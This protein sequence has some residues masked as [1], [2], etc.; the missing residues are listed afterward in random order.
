MARAV[1]ISRSIQ[2]RTS[3][4]ADLT[5]ST[6]KVKLVIG[7]TLFVLPFDRAS[8]HWNGRPRIDAHQSRVRFF[9]AAAGFLPQ[10]ERQFG[11]ERRARITWNNSH[12][13][14]RRRT[15]RRHRTGIDR[16][17]TRGNPTEFADKRRAAIARFSVELNRYVF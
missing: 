11:R 9:R 6:E 5:C 15:V 10:N 16:R 13:V 3:G 14:V 2:R 1:V 4:G 7:E 17:S 12:R 8:M